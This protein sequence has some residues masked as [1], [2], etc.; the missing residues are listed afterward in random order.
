MHSSGEWGVVLEIA[1]LL[2]FIQNCAPWPLTRS[3]QS[4]I[5]EPLT[6]ISVHLDGT[7]KNREDV[8]LLCGA[9]TNAGCRFQIVTQ[10][11]KIYEMQTSR[12]N[13]NRWISH[14]YFSHRCQKL[15]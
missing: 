11:F 7:I 9:G 12:G 15:S 2:L 4:N 13:M 10:A 14:Q 8:R 5:A 3:T 1:F 6:V